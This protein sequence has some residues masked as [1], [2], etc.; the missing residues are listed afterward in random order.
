MKRVASLIPSG[1]SI[2]LLCIA[3]TAAGMLIKEVKNK[4]GILKYGYSSG[5]EC[6]WEKC[7]QPVE[8]HP[9]PGQT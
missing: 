2:R 4:K 6:L 7:D 5:R 1:R 3:M 9:V 8:D